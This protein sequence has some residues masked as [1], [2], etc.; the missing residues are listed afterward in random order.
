MTDITWYKRFHGTWKDPKFKAAAVIAGATR[1]ETLSVWDAI[2]DESSESEQR[3]TIIKV[4]RRII[5]AGLDLAIELVERIWDSFVELGMI[6]GERIAAWLKRQGAAA[7]K[8]AARV[9]TNVSAAAERTRRYRARKAEAVREPELPFS[10]RVT[11]SVTVT[12]EASHAASHP[13]VDIDSDKER[14]PR[15]P[16][17]GPP[18]VSIERG[19][20]KQV[21]IL[22]PISGG[23]QYGRRRE[24]SADRSMREFKEALARAGMAGNVAR[25]GNSPC[26]TG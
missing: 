13:P 25:Y 22:M 3:G 2:L 18:T 5:A 17:G 23:R 7:E 8:L 24:T 16:M 26:L 11:R 1:C 10:D 12:L 20:L 6:S 9:K 14:P 4:D 15:P 21:E 19:G